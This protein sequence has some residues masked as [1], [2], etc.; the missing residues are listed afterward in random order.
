MVFKYKIF[1]S[2]LFSLLLLFS[3]IFGC[4]CPDSPTLTIIDSNTNVKINSTGNYVGGLVGLFKTSDVLGK[5]NNTYSDSII[6]GNDT[7]GGIIGSD[8]IYDDVHTYSNIIANSFFTGSISC[9]SNCGGFSG[10]NY[11]IITNSF[12][13]NNSNNPSVAIGSDDNA[14]TITAID[15]NLSYFYL[16]S[17]PPMD[18]WDSNTWSWF[19]NNLPVLK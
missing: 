10:K 1:S 2:L 14:Q 17:N 15:D 3:F 6:V 13:N 4:F 8:E 16:Q 12:Y 18:S 5:I 19:A 7:V 9:N 11:G